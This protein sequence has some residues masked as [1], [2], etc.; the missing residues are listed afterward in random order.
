M[1]KSHEA[2]K[3]EQQGRAP[4]SFSSSDFT[5]QMHG[6]SVASIGSAIVA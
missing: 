5:K 4:L 1:E 2:R 6:L 3:E